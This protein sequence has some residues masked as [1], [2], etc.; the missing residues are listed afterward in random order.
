M[1]EDALL[2]PQLELARNKER[3]EREDAEEKKISHLNWELARRGQENLICVG[4]VRNWKRAKKQIKSYDLFKH[5]KFKSWR[6]TYQADGNLNRWSYILDFACD[7]T[8]QGFN[9]FNYSVEVYAGDGKS[10][11][12][13]V[14]F[15]EAIL[16]KE[17]RLVPLEEKK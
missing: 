2:D 6:R 7:N 13:D 17:N 1:N 11:K 4:H 14:L 5:L 12:G 10:D 9:G 16:R 3:R 15:N 8:P